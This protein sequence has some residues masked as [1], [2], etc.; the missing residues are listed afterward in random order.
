MDDRLHRIE[1]EVQGFGDRLCLCE[2]DKIPRWLKHKSFSEMED[3]N[4]KLTRLITRQ[5]FTHCENYETYTIL[6]MLSSKTVASR[7]KHLPS[8]KADNFLLL[9]SL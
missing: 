9:N 1:A 8:R 5:D 4:S 2:H 3:L 7:G 6:A